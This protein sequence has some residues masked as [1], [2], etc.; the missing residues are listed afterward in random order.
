V[1]SLQKE[2][3]ARFY[4]NDPQSA[5]INVSSPQSESTSRRLTL[6]LGQEY[7]FRIIKISF[8]LFVQNWQQKIQQKIYPTFL[9]IFQ[10][11]PFYGQKAREKCLNLKMQTKMD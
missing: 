6:F 5:G 10:F 9:M 3:M 11:C 1:K 2:Q 7:A 4:Y 8:S